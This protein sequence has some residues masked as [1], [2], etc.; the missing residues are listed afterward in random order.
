MPRKQASALQDHESMVGEAR[1]RDAEEDVFDVAQNSMFRTAVELPTAAH[2]RTAASS[3]TW[4]DDETPPAPGRSLQRLQ[5]SGGET[6]SKGSTLASSP[7]CGT[8]AAEERDAV[9]AQIRD[10]VQATWAKA[11][12]IQEQAV[13]AAMRTAREDIR[14]E[15]QADHAHAMKQQEESLKLEAENA[16]RRLWEM[17]A[18]ERDTAVKAALAD[19][20]EELARVKQELIDQREKA[21]QEL[22]EA[23]KSLKAE[24]GRVVE[25]QHA[26]NMNLAVQAAWERAGRLQE[27]AV[28]A[29]RKEAKEQAEKDA[30]ERIRLERLQLGAEMRKTLQSSIESHAG[31]M[32]KD[33]EEIKSLR[34]QLADARAAARSAEANAAKQAQQAVKDAMKA[35]EQVSKAAQDRAVAR[36]LAEHVAKQATKAPTD[37]AE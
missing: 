2:R 22:E 19:Q 32:N 18:R 1:V 14:K 26:V 17:A 7:S 28:A 10:A 3:T 20:A 30:D 27:T 33:M 6:A 31:D 4:E 16:N 36:A 29:A 15:L 24:A 35:M 8:S 21:A 34:S 23:Y 25:E 13:A 11:N 37:S 9:A 12:A 5:I